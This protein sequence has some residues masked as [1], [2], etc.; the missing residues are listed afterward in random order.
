MENPGGK[1]KLMQKIDPTKNRTRLAGREATTRRYLPTAR[2]YRNH[3]CPRCQS[4]SLIV[5]LLQTFT[6]LITDKLLCNSLMSLHKMSK[7]L[8]QLAG[9]DR[10]R[11]TSYLTLQCSRG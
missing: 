1:K 2:L 11:T 8:T 3:P 9:S 6:T 4:T 7:I 5:I 10:P